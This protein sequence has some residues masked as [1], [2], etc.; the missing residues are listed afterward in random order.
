MRYFRQ[1]FVDELNQNGPVTIAGFTWQNAEVFEAM[2]PNDYEATF[3]TWVQ[4]QKQEAKERTAEFLR[5]TQCLDRFRSL[6]AK[7]KTGNVLPFVGAGLSI[8]S[9][10]RLW[11]AFLTSLLADAPQIRAQVEQMLTDRQYEEAAQLVHDTLGAGVFAEEIHNQLGSHRRAVSGPVALLPHLFQAE[12]FTTNFDYVATNAYTNAGLP[13][14]NDFSGERLREARQRIGNEPHCL[15]RLHGEAD[16]TPGR[17]LT[18]D[19][20]NAAYNGD[21]TLT[22]ILGALLGQRSLLF[23]GSGLQSDR[24][25][26]ALFDIKAVSPGAPIRHYAF[27]PCPVDEERASRRAFLSQAEIHPIYYPPDEHDQCIEDLLITLMEGGLN[28]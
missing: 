7:V 25:Y 21:V 17:V 24:T 13:F 11:G 28:D 9:G 23:M 27:L 10:F 5:E 3:T 6:T 20:Y 1:R 8:P 15:L 16:A 19:E 26:S 2:A 14:A 22:R 18:R 4:A 12:V